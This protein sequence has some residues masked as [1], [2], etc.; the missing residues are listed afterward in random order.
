LAALRQL[1]DAMKA[2][3]AEPVTTAEVESRYLRAKSTVE[4]PVADGGLW[5]GRCYS[6]RLKN[7]AL[8]PQVNEDQVVGVFFG[9]LTNE[10]A[11]LVLDALAANRKPWG[12]RESF[13]YRPASFGYRPGD[14][15]NGA[16]WPWLN[17]VDAWAR[18][19]AGRADEAAAILRDVA[20]HDLLTHARALPHE[21]LDGETGEPLRNAPQAWNAAY[22]GAVFHGLF[23]VERN[24]A[25]E[26][27]VHPRAILGPGW[28]VRVPVVE[29]EVEV[30]DAVDAGGPRVRWSLSSPLVV[31]VRVPGC[32]AFVRRLAPGSG[33]KV[34][35]K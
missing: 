4:K 7:G 27:L 21:C 26:L 13:P 22:F 16:V 29:G 17:Y 28:R 31:D 5:N 15:A 3:R 1:G 20:R 12:F 23:G 33:V 8:T 24:A 34:L 10:R 32:A 18:F 19:G 9:E 25:G 30:A 2:G 14:Y 35:E 6:E 11:R